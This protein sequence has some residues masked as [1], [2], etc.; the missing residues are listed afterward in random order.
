MGK[1]TENGSLWARLRAASRTVSLGNDGLRSS[2][3]HGNHGA[4]VTSLEKQSHDLVLDFPKRPIYCS[5]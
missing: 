2:T 1:P 5:F 3:W 4:K